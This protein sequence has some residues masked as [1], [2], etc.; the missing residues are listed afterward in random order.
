MNKVLYGLWHIKR[1]ELLTVT[2]SST[3]GSNCVDVEYNLDTYGDIYWL[4]SDKAV[5]DKACVHSEVWYNA[6]YEKPM[7]S[8][9]GETKVVKVTL[10]VEDV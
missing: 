7:N 4:V 9:I 5:A 1:E 3:D 8:Y 2:A 10:Q 6:D